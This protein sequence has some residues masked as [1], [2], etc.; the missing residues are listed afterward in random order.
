MVYSL[1]MSSSE[2]GPM[3]RIRMLVCTTVGYPGNYNT[4][5]GLR[6]EVVI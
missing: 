3:L 4:V 6:V 1:T 2:T 5:K